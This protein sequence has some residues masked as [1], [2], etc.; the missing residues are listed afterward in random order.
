MAWLLP[1][2]PETKIACGQ[3]MTI[4]DEEAKFPPLNAR[5]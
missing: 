3:K 1:P 5:C 2:P 4:K